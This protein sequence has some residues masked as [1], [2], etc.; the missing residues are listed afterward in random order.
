MKRVI[1]EKIKK[2]RL[3]L[4]VKG[5]RNL[6]NEIKKIIYPITLYR[7]NVNKKKPN[8]LGIAEGDIGGKRIIVSLTT[9]PERIEYV[10]KTLYSILNQSY[11]P[12]MIILW[13]AKVQFPGGI[14]SLP[15]ELTELQRYGLTIEWVE[16]DWKPYKKIIPAL[17]KY[18]DDIIVTADDDLYYP[19]YWLKSLVESYKE[20]PDQIHGHLSTKVTLI[21]N[22]FIFTDRYFQ[23]SPGISSYNNKILGGAGTLFPPNTLFDDVTDSAK[24]IALAPTNDDIW[25]WAM[26]LKKRTKVRWI[27]N[28][29][30]TLY[31]VEGTQEDTP[32]LV[33]ENN[34]GENKRQSQTKAVFDAYQLYDLLRETIKS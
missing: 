24:F 23:R 8:K 26:A 7:A 22:E 3:Y 13:L 21:D 12:N 28:N 27:H 32:C 4:L 30:P 14:D 33:N 15:K 18:P 34:H 16:D 6:Q 17:L 25:L 10:H 31:W 5:Y 2:S 9:F 20:F 11:H 1:K 29:M 19:K